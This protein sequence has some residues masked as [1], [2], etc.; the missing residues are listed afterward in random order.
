[1]KEF[2]FV[3]TGLIKKRIIYKQPKV[4]GRCED[5]SYIGVCQ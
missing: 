2:P 4:Q 1:M 5:E 3:P